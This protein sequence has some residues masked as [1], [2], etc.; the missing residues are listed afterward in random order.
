MDLRHPYA[1]GTTEVTFTPLALIGR[2]CAI[3]PVPRSHLVHFHGVLAPA[4]AWRSAI[5]PPPPSAQPT[6]PTGLLPPKVTNP[7]IPWADLLRRTFLVDVR[8]CQ[9]CG[10]RM[11]VRC[12][13]RSPEAIQRLLPV[14]LRPSAPPAVRPFPPAGPSPGLEGDATFAA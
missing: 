9:S 2:I 14:L 1:D 4:A 10:G 5:V 12:L 11:R 7:W 3:L 13:V 6:E 8:R